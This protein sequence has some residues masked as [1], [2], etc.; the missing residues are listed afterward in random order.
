[1]GVDIP[2]TIERFGDAIKYVHFRDVAGTAEDFT[3]VW[4]DEGPT[5]MDAAIK[6]YREIGYD[7]VARPDHVPT[8]AG[9][10]ND[11]PGYESK[12]RLFAIGYMTGPLDVN[13]P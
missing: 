13:E 5:D 2:A 7:G 11:R 10:S 6:A 8:M 9:E 4:H 3:E 1:M 12:G